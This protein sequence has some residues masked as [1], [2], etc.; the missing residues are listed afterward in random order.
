MKKKAIIGITLGDQAG[1]GPEVVA[2]A[3][4][5]GQV[6]T[7]CD[8]RIIGDKIDVQPGQP[9][10]ASAQAAFDALE[11]SVQ[12]L[13]NGEIDAVVTAPVG[14]EGLHEVGFHFPG[15]TEFF[16]DR[17]QCQNHAM[18]LTGKN[19][20]VALVTIHVALADVPE[21]LEK[22]EIVR[23]GKLIA[24]FCQ[25]RGIRQPRVAVCGLNPHAGEN[26]AF[27]KEDLELVEPAV[28]ELE[29]SVAGVE[30][31]GPHPPDT[32]FRPAADGDYDAVLCMYHDQGLIPLKLLD[33]D[34]GVNVTL[35]LPYP[36]TSPDHGTAY[37]I[38]GTG[39]ASAS[40][41]VHAI[42]LACEMSGN[43]PV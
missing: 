7:D 41:M 13:K 17:L 27:G 24:E 37:D 18:C 4:T 14:K 5:S 15:Q 1:I 12:L 10:K 19:L 23:I 11:E 3:L 16:A 43:C 28:R 31:S 34:T 32:I 9:T 39:K 36:R 2:A 21:L 40:S 29:Q 38:A 42:Q 25:Q 33:F 20:T 8:Y 22:D 35:G 30:F 6:P 26:G